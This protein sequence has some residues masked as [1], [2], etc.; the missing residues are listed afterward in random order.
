MKTTRSLVWKVILEQ[1]TIG[2]VT[3]GRFEASIE[4]ERAF[5]TGQIKYYTTE[6]LFGG[7]I[8]QDLLALDWES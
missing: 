4:E 3:T 5:S 1:I 2:R 7:L 6:Y 8:L